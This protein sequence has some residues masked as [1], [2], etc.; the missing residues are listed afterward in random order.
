MNAFKSAYNVLENGASA[1][2]LLA[3]ETSITGWRFKP[4]VRALQAL[5]GAAAISAISLMAEIGDRARFSHPRRLMGY[6]GLV[7][8]KNSIGE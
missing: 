4:V 1:A 8:S 2:T 7:P 3:L 6:L 5:R